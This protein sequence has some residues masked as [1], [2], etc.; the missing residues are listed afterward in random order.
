VSSKQRSVI[1]WKSETSGRKPTRPQAVAERLPAPQAGLS[2]TIGL[3][4]LCLYAQK[5][6]LRLSFR[7]DLLIA[8][9]PREGE[10]EKE[11]SDGE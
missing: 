3:E 11:G 1:N 2:F 7:G 10:E 8:D 4:S 5:Y 6:D 9:L